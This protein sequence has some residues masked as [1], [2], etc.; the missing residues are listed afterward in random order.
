M[1]L[2]AAYL[3]Q[4]ALAVDQLL[5]ALIPPLT[6]TLSYADETLSARCYRAWRDGRAWGRVLLPV[7][8]FLF[9]WQTSEHCRKAYVKEQERRNLPPEYRI[10]PAPKGPQP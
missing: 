10:N 8:D 9:R 7:I 1:K 3:I 2:F 6:G 5:N 4:I